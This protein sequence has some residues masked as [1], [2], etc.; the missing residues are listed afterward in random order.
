MQLNY[1]E[2]EQFD[3]IYKS[4]SLIPN[5]VGFFFQFFW[6]VCREVT[7]NDFRLIHLVRS[8]LSRRFLQISTYYCHCYHLDES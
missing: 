1:I 6:K 5:T 2:I 3:V 8:L 7:V 4:S